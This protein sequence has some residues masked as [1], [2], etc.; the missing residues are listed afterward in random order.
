[1]GI[2]RSARAH[3]KV[4]AGGLGPAAWRP[5]PT[6]RKQPAL[7]HFSFHAV[8]FV[9]PPILGPGHRTRAVSAG[10]VLT[11]KG[12]QGTCRAYVHVGVHGVATER[13]RGP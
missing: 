13:T 5:Q 3:P 2:L 11:T 9:A 1:M 12:A 4:T 10:C 8:S 6:C 7:V